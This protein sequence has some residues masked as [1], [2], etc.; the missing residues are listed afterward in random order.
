MEIFN[1]PHKLIADFIE[2]AIDRGSL[3][4]DEVYYFDVEDLGDVEGE[5]FYHLNQKQAGFIAEA[6][7]YFL[8]SERKAEMLKHFGVEENDCN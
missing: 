1:I 7:N 3:N 6:I 2:I 5:R 4:V 8:S